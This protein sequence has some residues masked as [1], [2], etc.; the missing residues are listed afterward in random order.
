MAARATAGATGRGLGPPVVSVAPEQDVVARFGRPGHLHGLD[1]RASSTRTRGPRG[2]QPEQLGRWPA[3]TR[4]AASADPA[5]A[6][7]VGHVP[8]PPVS[9]RP[10]GEDVPADWPGP[11]VDQVLGTGRT[12][13]E[14]QRADDG[15]R[16]REGAR[17]LQCSP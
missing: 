5:P 3:W 17:T 13:L 8:V 9:A 16:M 7:D 2:R 12:G 10:C 15:D 4:A 11:G 1:V 6:P 14:G